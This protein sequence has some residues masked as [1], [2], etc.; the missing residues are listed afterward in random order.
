MERHGFP[1]RGRKNRL[2][3]LHGPYGHAY[4]NPCH[5]AVLA[6]LRGTN[7]DVQIP[8]RLPFACDICGNMPSIAEKR[9]IALAAQRAQDAQTGY[10]SDYCS[11]NQP[12]GFHEIK[13]FQKGHIALHATLTDA[14]LNSSGKRHASRLLSDAY[15]KGL[16]RGQVESCNLRAN[17]IEGQ[18]VAAE[19]LSTTGF[20]MFPGHVFV[21]LLEQLTGETEDQP[22]K[23]HY[24]KTSV[25]KA[26]G[27]KHLRES[28]TV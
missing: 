5:P 18:I 24:V 12:M 3:A 15:C 6:A 10:C 14:D 21:R 26:N 19:R 8:Y 2:G 11:K 13:E 4:L 9:A 20:V 16:V 7:T 17:H 22:Q 28:M 25:P 27:S 23:R 1:Q